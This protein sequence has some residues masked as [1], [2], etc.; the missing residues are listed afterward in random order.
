MTRNINIVTL[1]QD[2][3]PLRDIEITIHLLGNVDTFVQLFTKANIFNS[4]YAC[5]HGFFPFRLTGF[6]SF[7]FHFSSCK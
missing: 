1:I 7:F 4:M 2:I 5:A 6:S 3:Q